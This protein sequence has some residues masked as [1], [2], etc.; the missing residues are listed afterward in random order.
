MRNCI[1]QSWFAA[2]AVGILAAALV[3]AAGTA[4]AASG[5]TT[6]AKTFVKV[7]A[8]LPTSVDPTNYQNRPSSD[9]LPTF[10]SPLVRGKGLPQGAKALPGSYAVDPFVALSWS[11]GPDGQQ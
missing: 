10:T 9:N 5:K 11:R 3:T 4:T 7:V 2:L 8:G 1:R 6:A